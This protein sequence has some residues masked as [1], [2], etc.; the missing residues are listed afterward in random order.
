MIGAI[1]LL[2]RT[3]DV[4]T[5][6]AE[7]ITNHDGWVLEELFKEFC[8]YTEICGGMQRVRTRSIGRKEC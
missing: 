6:A 7:M 4:F 8:K 3:S 1:D 2:I 5:E